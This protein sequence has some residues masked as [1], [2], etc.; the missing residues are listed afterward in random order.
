MMDTIITEDRT[1]RQRFLGLLAVLLGQFMLVLD[2]TVVN[3]ALPAMQADLALPPAQ[4]TWITNAYMIAF[5]GLLLLF[6]RLGDQL[7]R[8]RMFV[9]GISLFT[10]ASIACGLAPTALFLIVARFIQG[11]GA[12]AA[13]AVIL[14][15][16]ATE[17]PAP[18]DRAKAMSGYMFVSVSGGSLGLFVGGVLTQLLS[19][20]WIFWINVPVGL[21]A[22]QLVRRYVREEVRARTRQP[23]DVLGALLVTSAAMV[24]IYGLV[25]A[26]RG[27]WSDAT[28][29]VS[30]SITL[31]LTVLFF[32]VES[33]R[34]NPLLPLRMLRIRSLIVTSVIRGFMA[35]GLYG[36]FF[37]ATLDMS[38]TL[39]FGPFQVG[40][41]FL[42]QTLV[43]AALSLGGSAWLVRRFGPNRVLIAGLAIAAL[44]TGVMALLAVDEPYFPLR[45][46]GHVLLGIGFGMSFLPLLTLA[47]SEVPASDAGLGS[48]IVNLS[49]QLAAAVD[50]A[51]LV[52]ASSYRTRSLLAAGANLRDATVLGYR[53]AYALGIAALLVGVTL[54]ATLLRRDTGAT[55]VRP[56]ALE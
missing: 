38:G 9:L 49:L 15:I 54:A 24:A 13:S 4:L 6:G 7:G 33:L 30:I 47:M 10:L 26:A 19:W 43:V 12:A 53:F 42:P 48:A 25:A 40:L 23:V 31:A 17:F 50:I 51:I 29:R 5:G 34:P 18:A 52:T 37:L 56:R 3:V 2:A 36:V 55:A 8:R 45:A 11:V 39:G 22:L 41:A 35:M 21:L 14:A 20:H 16:I 28:V 27:S 32:V 44:G 1:A 46:V